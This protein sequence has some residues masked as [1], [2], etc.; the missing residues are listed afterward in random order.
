VWR[1]Q[2]HAVHVNAQGGTTW[3]AFWGTR[4]SALGAFQACQPLQQRC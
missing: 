1:P 4:G 3:M 2:R